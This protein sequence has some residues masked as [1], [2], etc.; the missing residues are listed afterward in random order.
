MKVYRVRL[1]FR[2]IVKIFVPTLFLF[3]LFGLI[4]FTNLAVGGYLLLN[5]YP[6]LMDFMNITQSA[7]ASPIVS[8]DVI[9]E[10]TN[11]TYETL[12]LSFEENLGQSHPDVRFLSRGSEYSLFLT[13]NEAVLT[14]NQPNVN[15]A[16][17][18]C[19]TD[20]T[21]YE[22]I[23]MQVMGANHEPQITGI[24]ALPG[25]NNYFTGNC[26]GKW[27]TSVN[28]FTRVRY[29]EIYPGIDLVY[30]GNSHN[31]EFDFVVFPGA[32]PEAIQLGFEGMDK[33]EL[34]EKGNLVLHI[35][36]EKI[37][38]DAPVIYQEI[39]GI[40][41]EVD[42]G[43][44]LD[45][46]HEVGFR[47]GNFNDIL[48]LVI[49]PVLEFS[50]YLGGSGTDYGFDITL[51][52]SGDIYLTG[53]TNSS[54]F[55]VGNG[56]QEALCGLSDVFVTKISASSNNV[57]FTTYLGGS[58]NDYG[59]SL[60]VDSSGNAYVT[61]YTYSDDFPTQDAYQE[62][63]SG[64]SDNGIGWDGFVAK[65]S[66]SGDT[67]VYST[68]LGG[69]ADDIGYRIAVDGAGNTYIGGHTYS[70]DFPI[71]N[72]YQAALAGNADGFVVKLAP[73]GKAL[74]YSTFL[75]GRGGDFA[76]GIRVDSSGNAYV[77]GYTYSDDFP[78]QNAYQAI[79]AGGWDVFVTKLSP[80]GDSIIYSTYLGGSGGDHA[81]RIT[82]DISGNAYIGGLT[83]SDN[84]PTLNAC[85]ET[86]A[87]S[88][89]G[90]IAK[91]SAVGDALVYSTYLGGS[92]YDF[93]NGITRD[94]SGS[95]IAVGDTDSVDFPLRNAF[96]REFG[97]D[98]DTFISKISSSGDFLEYS[99]YLGG[100]SS[101]V[102]F[103]ITVDEKGNTY[104]GGL[105]FSPDFPIRLPFQSSNSGFSDVFVT[106]LIEQVGSGEV[107]QSS[108]LKIIVNHTS[109]EFDSVTV[110][111]DSTPKTVT[112]TNTSDTSLTF[113]AISIVGSDA[114][115]FSVLND[116]ISWQT[117]TPMENAAFEVVFG[118]ASA[119]LKLASLSIASAGKGEVLA[120]ITLTG[121]S[122]LPTSK[123][124][125]PSPEKSISVPE[126]P[127]SLEE[128]PLTTQL[129]PPQAPSQIQIS[130]PDWAIYLAGALLITI[131]LL[132]ITLL[133][134]V[135]TMRRSRM[136]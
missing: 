7:S 46:K 18:P 76:N 120:N 53:Q 15:I 69:S 58:D 2:K 85:Q 35:A 36:G 86:L 13:D 109:L 67:L 93:I 100:N 31:L 112:V 24:D 124:L 103:G 38:L 94:A 97:G 96:Q 57:V 132:L 82:T 121:T 33:L 47:V 66:P 11:D 22:V 81:Y 130:F 27:Q 26:S 4:S 56:Y 133:L 111:S 116:N 92:G 37:V 34:D 78:T 83:Y 72:A 40:K 88:A 55:P 90:F 110:G 45:A 74:E 134:L 43:Y 125:T 108:A 59:Y 3:W 64:G 70:S 87:G 21:E 102:G 12:P 14:L 101:D 20:M 29:R 60:A 39:E 61:G 104:I 52:S 122:M 113:G 51:D 71:K 68:Y 117:L 84:F 73:S 136:D 48:P 6:H 77:T 1:S 41:H 9:R 105:T 5:D 32:N 89:D 63:F 114:G 118:P 25:K 75:G 123:A 126:A 129:L 127:A 107:S 95:L 119:G 54:D 16:T 49:D 80:S 79:F 28:S 98:W 131:V 17:F 106:K 30:Y 50:T 91:L 62:I 44:I 23:R 8:H 10:L 99:T 128:L 115:S 135:V 65:L 42:G 19:I